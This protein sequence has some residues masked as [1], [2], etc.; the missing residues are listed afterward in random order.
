MKSPC[1]FS[2]REIS[3]HNLKRH[4]WMELFLPVLS[5]WDVSL[6]Y[7]ADM[8]YWDGWGLYFLP[9]FKMSLW[10]L[11][12]FQQLR[13]YLL[14]YFF[15]TLTT[16]FNYIYVNQSPSFN[17]MRCSYYVFCRLSAIEMFLLHFLPTFIN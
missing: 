8:S 11:A 1:L 16:D 2:V 5:K 17:Q 9:T 15:Q 3:L 13:W 4:V 10:R 7:I 6:I 12:N 14:S